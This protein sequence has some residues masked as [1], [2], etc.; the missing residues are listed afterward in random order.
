MKTKET[1]FF[2]LINILVFSASSWGEDKVYTNEDLK[3]EPSAYS[4][5]NYS[6]LE[7]LLKSSDFNPSFDELHKY[8]EDKLTQ[9][10]IPEYKIYLNPLFPGMTQDEVKQRWGVRIKGG[11]HE[12]NDKKTWF[13]D[14]LNYEIGVS[15]YFNNN[16]LRGWKIYNQ[17]PY[18][19]RK[20][21]NVID[22]GDLTKGSRG[23]NVPRQ[24][25]NEPALKDNEEVAVSIS[26]CQS[27][28]ESLDGKAGNTNAVITVLRHGRT[29]EEI[30]D[31]LGQGCKSCGEV[32]QQMGKNQ[33]R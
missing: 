17:P 22:Y 3:P 7:P 12:E 4:K 10:K 28:Q 32:P 2:L 27:L 21:T 6:S 33:Q 25:V 24:P 16:K 26:G 11:F 15:L 14:T 19:V 23:G 9:V 29:M 1:I 5:S 30:C 20:D 13:V 18:D 31:T 8:I